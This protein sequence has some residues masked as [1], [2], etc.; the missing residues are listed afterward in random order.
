MSKAPP[1][2][3][4]ESDAFPGAPHPRLGDAAHRPRRRRGRKCSPPT[5]TSGSP[6]PG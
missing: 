5:A 3:P 4:P 1:D 6:T 2:A